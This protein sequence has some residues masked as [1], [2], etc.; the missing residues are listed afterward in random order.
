MLISLCSADSQT[1]VA[2]ELLL[3]FIHRVTSVVFVGKTYGNHPVWN[4]AVSSLSK[5]VFLTKFLLLPFPA[6]LRPLI[7]PLI[8]QRNRVFRERV[9]VRNL[10]FPSSANTA[11]MTSPDE[12]SVMKLFI[13]SKKDKSPESIVARLMILTA[14]GVR[15]MHSTRMK[16]PPKLIAIYPVPHI[17]HGHIPCRLRP[18]RYAGIYRASA[19]RVSDSTC[20]GR[21]TVDAV[22]H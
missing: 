19:P 21:R 9:A 15:N 1:F 4:R 10:L 18:L 14:A 13:D 16:K 7:A 22:D 20:S 2:Y 8:P 17:V 5:D 11:T 12:L 3:A 6:M